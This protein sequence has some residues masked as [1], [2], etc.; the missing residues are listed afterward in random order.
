MSSENAYDPLIKRIISGTKYIWYC[1]FVCLGL[2]FYLC[3][4]LRLKL[5]LGLRLI[6]SLRLDVSASPWHLACLVYGSNVERCVASA[7]PPIQN[8]LTKKR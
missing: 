7:A 3:L 8:L 6:L 4:C 5:G 1:L 2:F